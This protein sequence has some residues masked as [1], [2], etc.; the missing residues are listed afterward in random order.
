MEVMYWFR[1]NVYAKSKLGF[2]VSSQWIVKWPRSTQYVMDR[3]YSDYCPLVLK[4][5]IID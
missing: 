2:L 3:S 1:T 5:S 4:N